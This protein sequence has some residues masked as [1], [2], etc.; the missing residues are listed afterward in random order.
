MPRHTMAT[1]ETILDKIRRL[2]AQYRLLFAAG[3][4]IELRA[5]KVN[6]GYGNPC[7]FAGYFEFEHLQSLAKTAL[8]ITKRAK[9]VY[10]TLNPLNPDLLG[11]A[12]IIRHRRGQRRRVVER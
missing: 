3:Q 9:G 7:T 4:V 5:L 12:A 2:A 6:R 10:F 11:A 1:A 8:D